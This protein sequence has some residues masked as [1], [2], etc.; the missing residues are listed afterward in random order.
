MKRQSIL[1]LVILV[2]V[3]S[4][5]PISL[6]TTAS[7]QGLGDLPGGQYWSEAR[8]VSADGSTVVGWSWSSS[9]VGE[10]FRWTSGGEMAALGDVPG[11]G[12]Y[13]IAYGVSGDGS[14]VAGDGTSSSGPEAFRW[15]SAGGMVGL[16]DLSGGSFRSFGS[17]V[18]DDGSV[19]VG[20]GT[21][22]SS[23]EAFRWTS[24]SGMVSLGDL[25]GGNS[26]SFAYGVSADG[27]VVVGYG[28]SGDS[29]EA[30]R[31]TFGEGLVGIGDLPGGGLDSYAYGVSPDGS[32]IV[33]R[34]TSSSGL[35]A[36][37]WTSDDGM[38]GLGDL[39]GGNF[40]SEAHDVSADGSVV[41]GSSKSD[42]GKEAFIWDAENGMRNLKD[43]LVNDYGLNLD[44]WKLSHAFG[45]SDDGMTIVGAGFNP[46]GR[47][48]GWIATIP[49]I[50]GYID[51]TDLAVF[52]DRWLYE[53]CSYSNY[54]CGR[55]D[56]DR[57]TAVDSSDYSW[58]AKYWVS[59]APEPNAAGNPEPNDAATGVSIT[60]DLS[61]KAGADTAAHGVY[62]G[63]NPTPDV[64]EF[65]GYQTATIFNPSTMAAATT[66]YWRVDEVG[67]G[68]ET[69]GEV[70]SF[71][72]ISRSAMPG[73]PADGT[74]IPG[75]LTDMYIW[76]K[77]I[78]IPGATAVEHTGYFN[79]DYSKVESRAEDANLGSPPFAHVPGWE[80]VFF[81][82]YP[83]APPADDSL[84]RGQKYYWTVDAADALGN[85]FA[86][87][88]WEFTILGYYAFEPS[89]PNEATF[90]ETDVL[91]SWQPGFGVKEHDIYM[92]TSWEDVNNARYDYFDPPPE[93]VATV[94]EPNILV[95]GLLDNTR[96]YWRIDQVD[97]D[98]DGFC[99]IITY[100][101]GDVWCFT[102][103]SRSAEPD[104]PADGVVIPGDVVTYN[105]DDY[106]WTRLVFIPGPTAVGHTGYF[107]EDYSKVESRAEDANLGPPPYAS[108][109][110]WKYVFFA[111]NPQVPPAD[112]SLVRGTKYF[113][114]VDATDALGNTSPGDIWEFTILGFY[115]FEPSP[116]NEATFVETDVL[117]SWQPGYI[118][119]EHDI[120]M[121][122]SWEDVNN[123]VY[124]PFNPPP[125]FVATVEEPNIFVTGLLDN[126]TYYWRVDEVAGRKPPFP[127]PEYYKGDVWCFTTTPSAL[128]ND[129]SI[130]LKD[131]PISSNSRQKT[132]PILPADFHK[133]D[134]LNYKDLKI[135][136]T[137]QR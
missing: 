36:Y 112:E 98:R 134:L 51:W 33:G 52:C 96:Y 71:T 102:T 117:L 89:P 126:T 41:V 44:G 28:D 57:N 68:G 99:T 39:P 20:W 87:D 108:I 133:N 86:G 53:G 27:S 135:L 119:E 24:A 118:V 38:V 80:Y 10:A 88:I 124:N 47:N 25:P 132:G 60:A 76:T 103:V 81:A 91:L 14:V 109:P 15:T 16:G 2:L 49:Y 46:S 85:T 72:T 121:G 50:V 45:V 58:L 66:Y 122:T 30:F 123:V 97:C 32:F 79:E 13:S 62:F 74:V 100:Y 94:E 61:W 120:Y 136:I 131:Y 63:T 83:E 114:T 64:S 70:W 125:E 31:W 12:V 1:M 40:W 115:A 107:S 5:T 22:S 29:W 19:V 26:Y 93:F 95:T 137:G 48:E 9:S 54:W 73:F 82:G 78:F 37:R 42:L 34:G 18:S 106:I 69:T 56:I 105:G 6:G 75:Y 113:W 116:P 110:G 129:G 77:L 4:L 8:G 104:F 3:C 21:S 11:G 35:E 55:A 67:L 7:F 90:V 130:N 43:V 92:G 101:T 17:D 59:I 65:Q 23:E 84:V 127:L 128:N 111:G